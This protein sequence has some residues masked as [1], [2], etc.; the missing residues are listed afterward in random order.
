MTDTGSEM[1]GE[2]EFPEVRVDFQVNSLCGKMKLLNLL[3]AFES[4]FL[5]SFHLFIFHLFILN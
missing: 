1:Q 4:F 5:F 2:E 3:L